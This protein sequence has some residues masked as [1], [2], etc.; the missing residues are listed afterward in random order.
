[1]DYRW[2][3]IADDEYEDNQNEEAFEIDDKNEEIEKEKKIK[4]DINLKK[5]L[6]KIKCFHKNNAIY[7]FINN[8]Y[9]KIYPL[10]CKFCNTYKCFPFEFE[11]QLKNNN[12][13]LEYL[14]GRPYPVCNMCI[15]AHMDNNEYLKSTYLDNHMIICS[16]G[17]KYLNP[18]KSSNP[19]W[20]ECK[21][22]HNNSYSHRLYKRNEETFKKMLREL[23]VNIYVMNKKELLDYISENR[24][25]TG[26][27][28]TPKTSAREITEKLIELFE[29]EGKLPEFTDNDIIK[30]D[31]TFKLKELYD[32]NRDYELGITQFKSKNKGQIIEL[33]NSKLKEKLLNDK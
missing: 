4:N 21:E 23:K 15:D 9:K 3:E 28:I 33:I 18:Y 29:K 20:L 16:C 30:V 11:K 17:V 1:M 2:L 12:Y 26:F 22:K 10:I 24:I 25:N 31:K 8:G 27:K 32:I 5:N 13:K 14:K 19:K 7:K 6:R